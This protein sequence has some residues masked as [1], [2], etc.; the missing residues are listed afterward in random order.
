M[1]HFEKQI[2]SEIK[3]SGR[4]VTV[5][6]DTAE[7]I[8]GHIVKREVVEHSGGV[9]VVPVDE[10]G[11]V[12]AVRQF[13][14]PFMQELLEIPAGKLEAGEEPAACAKRELSEETG[15]KASEL[16]CLGKIYPSPG[17]CT[18]TLFLFLALG[19][20]P[21]EAHPDADEL[22]SIEKLPLGSFSEKIMSGEICDAKTV[23]GILKAQNY[24]NERSKRER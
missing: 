16:V 9:A 22:L 3:Y 19:L 21:G 12:I 11:L 13:R 20:V 5:R 6:N 23:A 8:N 15:Y 1:E 14:Y 24:L 2:T 10:D 4:I 17:Y 7:L 18:E